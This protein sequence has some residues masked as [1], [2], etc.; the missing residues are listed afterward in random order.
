MR[1]CKCLQNSSDAL[2]ACINAPLQQGWQQRWP[3]HRHTQPP[4]LALWHVGLAYRVHL[5]WLLGGPGACRKVRGYNNWASLD[6]PNPFLPLKHPHTY[7]PPT[8]LFMPGPQITSRSP[9][10]IRVN[11]CYPAVPYDSIV[12]HWLHWHTHKFYRHLEFSI[13]MYN[14][15]CIMH[16]DQF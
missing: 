8:L 14:A 3:P 2:S 12:L 5:K 10:H 9:W 15:I 1:Y 16:L 4:P 13:C 6:L 7:L 11:S